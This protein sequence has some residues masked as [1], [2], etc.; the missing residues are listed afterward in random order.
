MDRLLEKRL[1]RLLAH[2]Q[3]TLLSGGKKGLEKES[4]RVTPDGRI[5]PT[6]HPAALGAPLTHT[7]ITTDYSEALLELITVPYPQV[8]SALAF[9]HQAHQF[10]HHTLGDELLWATSMPCL[11]DGEQNIP[12]ARYGS[13]NL[14]RLKHI[15]R[16]GLGHRYGHAMQ[17]IAGVHLNYSLPEAFWPVFQDHEGDSRPLK[18]FISDAYFGLIRNLQRIGWLPIY[19]FGA[20]PA[21]CQSFFGDRQPNLAALD[22]GTYF[23]PY[24][25]SLRMSDVGYRNK[26][27]ASLRVC[28]DSLEHYLASLSQALRTPYPEYQR[29]GI[30]VDG[31]YRQL[32]ANLLQIE[33]EYYSTLRPKRTSLADESPSL[34]LKRRG[35]EYVELR[36][37]DLDP[38][39]PIGVNATEVRFLEALLLSCLLSES[40]FIDSEERQAINDNQATVARQGR[41]PSLLLHH[42]ENDK[43]FDALAMEIFDSLESICELLDASEIGNPYRQ[44]LATLKETV[45]DPEQTPSARVLQ[46]MRVNHESF[47]DFAMRTAEQHRAYF[48]ARPLSEPQRQLFEKWAQQSHLQQQA[49]EASD[50]LPFD[51]YRIRY[52]S[53]I[54]ACTAVP[55]DRACAVHCSGAMT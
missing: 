35:V 17:V 14:G 32:N 22:A 49:L 4:L 9:L 45:R 41:D 12:L 11:L 47:F 7:A 6:P 34:A 48:A 29:I 30:I 37:L 20:S 43:S 24:A 51:E 31:D 10:V 39:C 26:T 55:L 19:L 46:A 50:D 15:Y 36:S 27:P 21:L 23:A 16:R 25:T 33:A 42:V 38:F 53:Q 1:S 13:S 40:P 5:A 44:S 52:L 18:D 54:E 8:Q 2:D 28:Y 3:R